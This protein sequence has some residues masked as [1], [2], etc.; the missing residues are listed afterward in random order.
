MDRGERAG[1]VRRA[2]LLTPGN[3]RSGRRPRDAGPFAWGP[4]GDRALLANLEVKG[5]GDAPTRPPGRVDPSASS[6]GRPIG[7]SIVFVG[8]GGRALL[9]A[10]SKRGAVDFETT[11]TQIVCDENGRIEKIIFDFDDSIWSPAQEMR[12]SFLSRLHFFGKTK[13]ICR[14]AA[15]VSAGNEFLANYARQW[16]DQVFVIPVQHMTNGRSPCGSGTSG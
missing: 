2:H 4:R 7:K 1:P 12:H 10:R 3:T 6:W 8:N 9:K 14:L 5:L 16:N 15:A 11:E 13:S